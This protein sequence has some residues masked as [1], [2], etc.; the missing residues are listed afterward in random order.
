MVKSVFS[1]L[2]S[3]IVFIAANAQEYTSSS[4]FAHNDYVHSIPFLS[5]YYEQVGFIEAD[6]FLQQ[7][8]LLV[9]H[10]KEEIK[11]E[12]NLE[13]LY[14]KPLWKMI[15]DNNGSVYSTSDK[16]LTLMID[17]KTEGISTLNML[18][19]KLKK[20][21]QLISCPTL[22]ITVSGNVPDPGQW[23]NYPSYIHFDGRP[24]ISY[25]KDQLDRVSLIST[26]FRNYS[27]WN[28]KGVLT[29]SER[30]KIVTLIDNVH[31]L[32]KK[33]RFWGA[34]DFNN[35]WIIMMSLKVD[36]L[37]TDDVSGLAIFLRQKSK[38]TYQHDAP[39]QVYEPSFDHS[40]TTSSPKN[41][42][43]MIGDGMGLTQLYSGYTANHGSLNIFKMKDIG[44]S[45]TTSA[46]S[47]ITDS[48]AGA[49]AMSTG[50]KTNNRFI[51]V[52]STG[53]P[54]TSVTE[55]LKQKG[56]RTAIISSG[57]ITDATPAAFYAHQPERSLS[58]AI[59]NDYLTS[60]NDI[61]IGGGTNAFISR[62][63]KHDLTTDLMKKGY[64][65]SDTFSSIDTIQN[66]KFIVL[67]QVA[68][69]SRKEG[70]AD[71]LLK[72][73]TKSIA[74]CTTD[75]L[76][77]F[78]MAEGAQIDHGGHDND[79]EFVVRELLDFDQA[80]GEVMKFVDRSKETLLIVT[81]DHETGGL[82]LLGGDISKGFVHGHF[83]TNDHTAVMVPVFAYGPGAHF[84]R[85]VY[86]NTE[87]N[88][89]ILKMLGV[90]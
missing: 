12:K 64:S 78:I 1:I 19:K 29:K 13:E 21:P 17:M 44:F 72:S 71:F 81:A 7:N 77:F 85:G 68:M 5:S 61:L 55:K 28:G 14:V 23:K 36:I 32:G 37:G 62:T 66:A 83:S 27:Q 63:D 16:T 87:I 47:Y 75:D 39:H 9:A 54:L 74:M 88:L 90:K 80:V 34:P 30:E 15:K 58:E 69:A 73:L 3:S 86:Q 79:L 59:A 8:D 57:D 51:G 38:N 31:T 43:L 10:T 45:V 2:V 60:E 35:A 25:T 50:N 49:T 82:S 70:R 52:D 24:G 65:F 56:F 4:I 41:I 67:D 84:F 20:Y 26:N 48:A 53:G 76:P 42:I 6:I 46:D 40:N 11:P 22:Q 33:I 18:V 89:K